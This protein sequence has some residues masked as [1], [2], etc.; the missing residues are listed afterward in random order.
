MRLLPVDSPSSVQV[1]QL[2]AAV[3]AQMSLRVNL[4]FWLVFQVIPGAAEMI[5]MFSVSK[6]SP[7]YK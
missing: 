2:G 7:Y 4:H 5:L 1:S 6:K 3:V